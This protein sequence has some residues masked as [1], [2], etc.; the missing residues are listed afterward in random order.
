MHSQRF[1]SF[2]RAAG[3]H[4]GGEGGNIDSKESYFSKGLPENAFSKSYV[5]S[6]LN[7]HKRL[8]RENVVVSMAVDSVKLLYIL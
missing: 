2:L 7:Y 1:I 5:S 3:G 6:L 8:L 4:H